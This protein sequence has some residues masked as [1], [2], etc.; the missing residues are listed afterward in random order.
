MPSPQREHWRY[1]EQEDQRGE[2]RHQSQSLERREVGELHQDRG[3]TEPLACAEAR[4]RDTGRTRVIVGVAGLAAAQRRGGLVSLARL[5][6]GW[7]LAD[8]R[9][10]LAT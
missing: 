5:P 4:E 8:T 10:A 7:S 9:S 6:E 2:C 1:S 3:H